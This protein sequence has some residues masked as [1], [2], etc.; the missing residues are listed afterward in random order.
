MLS[1][2]KYFL[3]IV[4]EG[5]ITTAAKKLYISQPALTLYLK[6]LEESLNCCLVDRSKSPLELTYAGK[7]YLSYVSRFQIFEKEMEQEFS[8]L[9]QNHRQTLRCGIAYW[10]GSL[11]LPSVLPEFSKRWPLIDFYFQEGNAK[12]TVSA[13][14]Q[15]EIDFAV[16]NVTTTMDLSGLISEEIMREEILLAVKAGTPL[17]QKI[18]DKTA[19]EKSQ[20]SYIYPIVSL[21]LLGNEK[22]ILPKEGQNFYTIVQQFFNKHGFHPHVLYSLENTTTALNIAAQG[23]GVCFVPSGIVGTGYLPKDVKLYSFHDDQLFWNLSLVYKRNHT[24]SQP[25]SDFYDTA[26]RMLFSQSNN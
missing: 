8:D 7:R 17:S 9:S 4:E 12:S 19:A 16:M 3:T 5:N 24:V 10:R 14:K 6:R 15:G 23:Q 20:I 25:I 22:F 18:D 11:F 1:N 2:Y 26:K 21:S 13:L